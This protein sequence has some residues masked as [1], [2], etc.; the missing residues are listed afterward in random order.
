M[1]AEGYNGE[2]LRGIIPR[3]AGFNLLIARVFGDEMLPSAL[4][5]TIEHAVEWCADNGA[6]LVNLSLASVESSINSEE[7]YRNLVEQEN[8]LVVAAAG[9]R[10]NSEPSYPASYEHVISVG[11]IDHDMTRSSYSQYGSALDF[12]AP[13][14][15]IYSTVPSSGVF[16]NEAARLDAGPMAFTPVPNDLIEGEIHN[17]GLGDVTC[18]DA[19]GKV[20][21]ME[22]TPGISF[23]TMAIHCE[24][25]GGIGLIVYPGFGAEDLVDAVMD[26]TYQGSISVVTVSR[27]SGLRLLEKRGTHASISFTV[28]SY[29]EVSGTSMSAAHVTGLLAKLWAARPE[30]TNAQLRTALEATALDLGDPGRDDQ[31]GHGLVQG[32]AAYNYLL[33]QPPPCGSPGGSGSGGFIPDGS[34]GPTGNI[35]RRKTPRSEHKTRICRPLNHPFCQVTEDS[36]SEGTGETQR[37][38]LYLRHARDHH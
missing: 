4:T 24:R 8:I 17:C 3:N 34:E 1:V 26:L 7:I 37:R 16:D 10:G 6:D 38:E 14:R 25:G 23:E 32:A 22:H 31:F 12:V 15:D 2:G 20:C 21:L 27:D 36:V 13:G 9:N 35:L 28:P 11:S 30:C 29:R 5:S 18:E 19:S 33:N